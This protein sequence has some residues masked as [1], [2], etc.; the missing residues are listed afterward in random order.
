[1]I[2]PD[3]TTL[4]HWLNQFEETARL[5]TE[6]GAPQACAA[7]MEQLIDFLQKSCQQMAKVPENPLLAKREP[8]DLD[9]IQQLCSEGPRTLWQDAPSDEVMTD[10]LMGALYG[11][12][13]GCLMG[14]PVECWSYQQIARW[15]QVTGQPFPPTDY[16]ER[17]ENPHLQNA[18][19]WERSAYT[20]AA[21]QTAPVDDDI[22]YT[23]LGLLILEKYGLNFTTEDVAEMWLEKL[24]LA[25][26]AE[27][28]VLNSLKRGIPALDAV[29]IENP[30]YQWIGAAIRSDA[31]GYAAAG[32]PRKA[33]E[34]AWQD[35]RLTH[36][37]NGIYGE[38]LLAA[39]QSAAF[40]VDDPLEAIRIGMTEIPKESR[41]YQD[42]TWALEQEV[43]DYQEAVELVWTHFGADMS[44][45]HTNNNLCL[46]VFGFKIGGTDPVKVLSQLV[47]MGMD[48]DCTAASAGSI[49]GAI[50]G[51]KNIP[52]YLYER[53]HNTMETYLKDTTPFQFDD[54]ARRFLKLQ[55]QLKESTQNQ[56]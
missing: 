54:M 49:I 46:I 17:V 48:N 41:L 35:A 4:H 13:I 38:M 55:H 50:V 40:A 18:Y 29:G 56:A 27:E 15:A 24:P 26:T 7:P 21:M 6:E 1:M 5:M 10:K 25:C 12:V 11:R 3:F 19:G 8:D 2:Y 30:F 34:M 28:A 22:I 9:T 42:L 43:K 20:R 45:V 16:F 37:R 47:A 53:F 33:A 44:Y 36:R 31:F 32:H 39:A 51:W 52:P 23:Q 14:V